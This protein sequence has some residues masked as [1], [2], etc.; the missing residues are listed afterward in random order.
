MGLTGNSM[1]AAATKALHALRQFASLGVSFETAVPTLA[2]ILQQVVGFDTWSI[3]PLN[4]QMQPVDLY[5]SDEI[6]P[7]II[8][9]YAERW[10]N[11]DEAR[12]YPSQATMQ[13][14]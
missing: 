6:N 8:A 10:L 2:A 5:I 3:A 12:F 4:A 9:R 1:T 13:T 14:D 7:L 11:Q